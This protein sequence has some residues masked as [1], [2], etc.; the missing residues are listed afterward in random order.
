M[1]DVGYSAKSLFSMIET[2]FNLIRRKIARPKN[3]KEIDDEL[4]YI[5]QNAIDVSN[6]PREALFQMG[7][8][9]FPNVIAYHKLKLSKILSLCKSSLENRLKKAG[10]LSNEIYCPTNV[11][12]Q[13]K[14]ITRDNYKQ[15]SLKHIPENSSFNFFIKTNDFVVSAKGFIKT[16]EDV[17]SQYN[18]LSQCSS[19]L[20]CFDK[21]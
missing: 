12:E 5:V 1:E 13:L 2:H 15:W 10:W 9:I 21:E 4:L 7:I 6:K 8:I 20:P 3:P 16:K 18:D 11:K 19:P 14:R 17:F